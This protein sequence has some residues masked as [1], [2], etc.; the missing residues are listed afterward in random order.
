MNGTSKQFQLDKKDFWSIMLVALLVGAASAL[1]YVLEN[2]N[3]F[4]FGKATVFI[5]PIISVSISSL[6]RWLKDFTKE[7][8]KKEGE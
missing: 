2:I 8:D 5:V 7:E 3:N 6:I 1:T 4:D